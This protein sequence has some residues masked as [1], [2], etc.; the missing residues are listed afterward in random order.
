MKRLLSLFVFGT[1]FVLLGTGCGDSQA[2][3]SGVPVP[4]GTDLTQH[5]IFG[6]PKVQE[7]WQD[8]FSFK[9]PNSTVPAENRG[10]TVLKKI[11]FTLGHYDKHKVPAWVA[12]RWTAGDFDKS[13]ANRDTPR[14]EWKMDRDLPKYAQARTDYEF[15]KF[16]YERGHMARNHD[17]RAW[18]KEAVDQGM[19][20]SN[21]VPQLKD[22]GHKVWGEL[23]DKHHTIVKDPE[24]DVK[25]LWIISGPVFKDGKPEKTIGNGVGV[26]YAT[27]KVLGWID[28]KQKFHVRA[29]IIAQEELPSQQRDYLTK[30]LASVDEVERQTGLDFFPDLPD[31]VEDKIEATKA[32]FMWE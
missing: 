8:R 29:Y 2:P 20:M 21:A 24:I 7:A 16:K 19:T 18:G 32:K 15:R 31:D 25:T 22:H 11:A 26:P 23:E 13:E 4:A 12:M 14:G 27:Y 10:M 1:L 9:Q 17:L 5:F 30:Y 6:Q 28:S 3:E